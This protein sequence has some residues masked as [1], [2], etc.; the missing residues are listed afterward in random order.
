MLILA[1]HKRSHKTVVHCKVPDAET[2][3][4]IMDK[5][6]E[7][8]TPYEYKLVEDCAI[9]QLEEPANPKNW[10]LVP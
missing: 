2:A 10:T 1:T 8:G 6:A 7:R 4:E 9:E 5:E 3:K